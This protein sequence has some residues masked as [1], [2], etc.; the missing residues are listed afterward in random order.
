MGGQEERREGATVPRMRAS[1]SEER[2]RQKTATGYSGLFSWENTERGGV[3]GGT[4]HNGVPQSPDKARG[5]AQK[6]IAGFVFVTSANIGSLLRTSELN[7][8]EARLSKQPK[9]W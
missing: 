3:G 2:S 9:C 1:V 4:Q 5:A 7:H 6:Q 8:K